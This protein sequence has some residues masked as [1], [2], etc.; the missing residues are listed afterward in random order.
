MTQQHNPWLDLAALVILMATVVAL[1][2][3]GNAGAA[4]L[5]AAGTLI[6]AGMRGWVRMRRG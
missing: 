3:F 2:V 6:A 1:V 5:T 4:V